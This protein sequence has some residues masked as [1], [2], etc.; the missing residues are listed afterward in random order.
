[1]L[2]RGPNFHFEIYKLQTDVC[3]KQTVQNAQSGY[4]FHMIWAGPWNMYLLTCVDSN[5]HAHP[6]PRSLI[7]LRCPHEES[8]HPWLQKAPSQESEQTAR[9]HRL[10][11]IRA[12]LSEGTFSDFAA[13][14]VSSLCSV[15]TRTSWESIHIEP[16]RP[17]LENKQSMTDLAVYDPDNKRRVYFTS[18]EFHQSGLD[19]TTLKQTHS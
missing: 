6:H 13:H 14:V 8:W 1:M 5:Q 12:G 18:D 17:S 2:K 19:T 10:I 3:T 7:S 4:S 15:L 16:L 11:W 9:M